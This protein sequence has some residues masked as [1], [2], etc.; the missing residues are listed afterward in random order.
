MKICP[1]GAEL[2]HADGRTDMTKLKA[3]F[4]NCAKALK[5]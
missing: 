4:R 1:A 2:F 3:V 5:N